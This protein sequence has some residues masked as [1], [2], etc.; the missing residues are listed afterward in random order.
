MKCRP[1]NMV[2]KC[3]DRIIIYRGPI[4]E[5]HYNKEAQPGELHGAYDA[6]VNN[7][8]APALP[9]VAFIFKKQIISFLMPCPV[10][11]LFCPG[12]AP[13]IKYVWRRHYLS[14]HKIILNFFIFKG[15]L[16]L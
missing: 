4:K 12:F 16:K 11:N 9:S 10:S 8:V 14:N 2:N 7:V 1:N 5:I 3:K 6:P 15:N 13:V